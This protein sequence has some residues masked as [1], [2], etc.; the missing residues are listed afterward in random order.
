MLASDALTAFIVISRRETRNATCSQLWCRPQRDATWTRLRDTIGPTP[1]PHPSFHFLL[2]LIKLSSKRQLT[3]AA[4]LCPSSRPFGSLNL[5]L[6]SAVWSA[7]VTRLG[8]SVPRALGGTVN[9][10]AGEAPCARRHAPASFVLGA[11]FGEMGLAVVPLA[12]RERACGWGARLGRRWGR[13][14]ASRTYT[15]RAR[16]GV[17]A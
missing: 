11:C 17:R 2:A 3:T 14:G 13:R 7:S 8:R 12:Y 5:I 16:W 4:P 10:R 1:T 9:G 6:R 15:V